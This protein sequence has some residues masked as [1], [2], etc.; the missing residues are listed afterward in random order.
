MKDLF[1]ENI[2]VSWIYIWIVTI[3]L[4]ILLFYSL[5]EIFN[6]LKNI[7]ISKTENVITYAYNKKPNLKEKKTLNE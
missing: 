4:F 2:I 5:K 6:I 3:V 7:K 1:L